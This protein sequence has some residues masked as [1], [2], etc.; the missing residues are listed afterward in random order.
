M[1]SDL[2]NVNVKELI[3]SKYRNVKTNID[4]LKISPCTQGMLVTF[5]D[6]FY[7]FSLKIMHI[8]TAIC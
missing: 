8:I 5:H 4:N 2:F 6:L 1:K 7:Y 3:K